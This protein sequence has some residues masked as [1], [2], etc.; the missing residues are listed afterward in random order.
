MQRSDQATSG[1]SSQRR[2]LVV[3]QDLLAAIAQGGYPAGSR[4][5]AEREI[6]LRAGVS[7]P[8]AREALLVLELIGAVKVRHG[9]GAFVCGSQAFV[10]GVDGSP[11][12]TPPRELIETRCTLEPMVAGLAARRITSDTLDA[13]HRNVDEAA[14]LVA[15]SAALPRFIA[16]GLRFHAEV[17]PGCGNTLLADIVIQLVNVENH[18]L[19]ALVNQQAMSSVG[20]RE[21]QIT[22]HRTVIAAIAGG[23]STRAETAMRQHLLTLKATI[24]DPERHDTR[25][26]TT[27]SV[28]PPA[29]TGKRPS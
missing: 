19:W 5:P 4:L 23:D 10:G 14:E 8:T 2:Y 11:L 22:D 13:V 7:R 9:D 26:A 12:D 16:L 24:F 3:A 27:T 29:L 20:A 6:A 21:N 17:A 15:E 18:P 25:A 28:R 1:S